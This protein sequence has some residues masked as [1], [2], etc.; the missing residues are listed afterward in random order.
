MKYTFELLGVSPILYFFNQQQE[1]TLKHPH[2][3][4]EY[5]G[6]FKCTL[7]AFIASVETVPSKTDWNFDEVVD[8]MVN[9]W[10]NNS[11]LVQFWKTRLD[12]AG[13][14]SLLVARVADIK[15][16]RDQLEYLLE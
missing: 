6:S 8:T 2:T 12:D 15:G 3:G 14:E 7:D 13:K 11:D 4:V 9:F 10:L 16:L 5:L 1:L